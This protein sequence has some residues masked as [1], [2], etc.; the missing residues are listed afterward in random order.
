MFSLSVGVAHAESN[1][2][3]ITVEAGVAADASA[4]EEDTEFAS[5]ASLVFARAEHRAINL[6]GVFWKNAEEIN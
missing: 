1:P 4:S 2:A 5:A 6:D 3:F